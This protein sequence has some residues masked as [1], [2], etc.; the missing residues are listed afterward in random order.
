ALTA[1]LGAL[2]SI[3]S[4]EVAEPV[5]KHTS[6]LSGQMWLEEILYGHPD[7]CHTQFGMSTEVFGRLLTQMY[8]SGL[9]DSRWVSAAEQLA[10]FL[11]F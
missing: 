8:A 3:S 11:Y 9:H 7:R 1:V 6:M 2:A 10:I 4:V 5:A